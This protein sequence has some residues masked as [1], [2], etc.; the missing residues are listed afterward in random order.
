MILVLII[1]NVIYLHNLFNVVNNFKYS[2]VKRHKAVSG[3]GAL[4]FNKL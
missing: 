3:Y 2:I 1:F 4:L